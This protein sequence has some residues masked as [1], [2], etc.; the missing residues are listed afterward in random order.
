MPQVKKF[1]SRDGRQSADGRPE[2][3]LPGARPDA[4]HGISG[5]AG[6]RGAERPPGRNPHQSRRPLRDRAAIGRSRE[7]MTARAP[8][9][10]PRRRRPRRGHGAAARAS[11]REAARGRRRLP[12][13]RA[14]HGQGHR[15][16]AA[17]PSACKDSRAGCGWGGHGHRHRRPGAGRGADR[18]R[19]RR[20]RGR[21]RARPFAGRDGRVA[22]VRRPVQRHPDHRR[23]HRHRRRRG[24]PDGGRRRRDQG[25]HRSWLDLHDAD[26]GRRWRAAIDGDH[27]RRCGAAGRAACR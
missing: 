4:A 11:D 10:G 7:L 25:R 2:T 20:D 23:Q 5:L 8:D 3:R 14:D 24:G 13:G 26:R 9:H 15:E 16:G 12:P 18:G 21:H 17:L 22:A 19:R 1:E 27:G 6:G